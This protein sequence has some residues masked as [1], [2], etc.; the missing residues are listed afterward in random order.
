MFIT[1]D[2]KKINDFFFYIVC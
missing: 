1:L 2:V